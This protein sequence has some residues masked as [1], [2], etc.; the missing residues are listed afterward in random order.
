[1]ANIFKEFRK[2]HR[3]KKL[4]AQ[5]AQAE[6]ALGGGTSGQED[7]QARLSKHRHAA[8]RRT[9]ITVLP[10]QSRVFFFLSKKEATAITRFFRQ[11]N[12]RTLF[13]PDTERWTGRSCVTVRRALL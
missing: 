2:N 7:Y 13:P 11:A 12:R 9:V 10:R 1:M 4:L 5:R 8:M 3:R 6:Q